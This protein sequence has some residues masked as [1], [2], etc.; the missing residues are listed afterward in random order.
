MDA[1]TPK[2]CSVCNV[3]LTPDTAEIN[4]KNG[5]SYMRSKCK[6]CKNKSDYEKLRKNH[7]E[8]YEKKKECNK[9]Q[10]HNPLNRAKFSYRD[11][12]NYDAIRGLDNDLDLDFVAQLLKTG[13]NYC[14]STQHLGLD[15]IDNTKGHLKSNVLPACLRCN[16][17]RRGMPYDAW[18]LLVPT[19][20]EIY[21]KGL[22]G[23][24][25]GG[26]NHHKIGK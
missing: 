2:T 21:Q 16:F 23:D 18:M 15:R 8:R 19:I 12:L 13:C 9:N 14:G 25:T 1:E 17:I 10:R 22:L 11:S 24:W 5:I 4:T 26:F 7:P 6:K 3:V 20:K